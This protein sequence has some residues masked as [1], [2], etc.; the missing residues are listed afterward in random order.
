MLDEGRDKHIV[1]V[2]HSSLVM[3]EFSGIIQN[4][5]IIVK[6]SLSEVLA[7]PPAFCLCVLEWGKITW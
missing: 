1:Y 3:I 7:P 6:K 4:G 2:F 5:D